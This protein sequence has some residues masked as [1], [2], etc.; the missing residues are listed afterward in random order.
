VLE[1]ERPQGGIYLIKLT[2][3]QRP[4]TQEYLG[5]LYVDKD[6]REG[7]RNGAAC[8]SVPIPNIRIFPWYRYKVTVWTGL[9]L[10]G[11]GRWRGCLW[12]GS[13]RR[14]IKC[15]VGRGKGD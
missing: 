4:A 10:D 6:F 9:K 13:T 1:S 12:I 5:E 7:H 14:F 3:F 15:Q 8:R 11:L 2:I